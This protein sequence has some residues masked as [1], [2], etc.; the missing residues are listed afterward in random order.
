MGLIQSTKAPKHQRDISFLRKGEVLAY[1]GRIHN[2][3]DLKDTR[4]EDVEKPFDS[5][6]RRVT[7]PESYNTKYTTYT[8]IKGPK[9]TTTNFGT[10]G[11]KGPTGLK[12]D[13]KDVIRK[14]AWPFYRTSPGVRLCWE[15]EEPKGPKG[16][17]YG[18]ACRWAM[19]G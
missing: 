19:L 7:Y 2:L 6:T 11:P 12:Q 3:K 4:Q 15:L 5:S 9:S 8:K 10:K 13:L 18:R 14:D 1:V 16:P 17:F